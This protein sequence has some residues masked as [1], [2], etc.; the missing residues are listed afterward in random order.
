MSVSEIAKQLG[1]D[2]KTVRRYM[3]SEKVP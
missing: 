1:I 3:S 2:G